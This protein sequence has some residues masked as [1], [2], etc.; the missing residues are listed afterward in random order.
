MSGFSGGSV[1]VTGSRVAAALG[2]LALAGCGGGSGTVFT[3]RA[4]TTPVASGR[5]AA[6]AS[7]TAGRPVGV[8]PSGVPSGVR[9]SA[10][11]SAGTPSTTGGATPAPAWL[12]TRV[13]AKAGV[14]RRTPRELRDRRIATTDLLPPPADG[15]FHARVRRVPAAVARRSTWRSG[16]P[17]PLG[18]LRYVTVSFVGFDGRAHTG[19]LVVHAAV[20][21]NVVSVFRR[22]F[23]ARF[24]IEEMR[25]TAASELDLPPTGDG[26]NTSAFVC[27]PTRGSTSWSAHAYGKA[28]DVNPFQNP[29]TRRS[30]QIPELATSYRDR[31]DRRPGMIEASGPVVRAF[32]SV[33]WTWGGQFRSLKD[34]MHFSATGR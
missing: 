24:P 1:I 11:P 17:V 13:L 18:R 9:P 31:S 15:G 2:V 8:T 19:E 6:A 28:I 16:C 14:A 29:Y 7:P 33:G 22:L 27:R 20:A 34:R 23:A 21:R 12:G 30:V 5:S 32:R 3:T 26:N 4:D 10:S 25:V